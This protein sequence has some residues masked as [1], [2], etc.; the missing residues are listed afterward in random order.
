[1]YMYVY[2]KQY[3]HYPLHLSDLLMVLFMWLLMVTLSDMDVADDESIQ[4]ICTGAQAF[5]CCLG[6]TRKA[7]GSAV[8]SDQHIYMY[9]VHVMY[10]CMFL[11][12]PF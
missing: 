7:A 5:F 1:M 2:T 8:S 10:T 4:R 12:V 6:T 9:T 11:N 3:V